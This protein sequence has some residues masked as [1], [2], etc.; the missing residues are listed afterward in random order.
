ERAVGIREEA[1]RTSEFIVV[2]ARGL[3]LVEVGYPADAELAARAE[4]TRAKRGL[5]DAGPID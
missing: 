2:P 1:R 4:Q 3:T 5:P